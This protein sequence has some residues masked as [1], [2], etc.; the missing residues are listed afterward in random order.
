MRNLRVPPFETEIPFTTTK[1]K[2]NWN[3]INLED[4]KWG[5]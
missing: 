2:E 4:R 3:G 1:R 5:A